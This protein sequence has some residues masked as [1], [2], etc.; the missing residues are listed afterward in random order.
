MSEI[1]PNLYQVLN[2]GRNAT[3]K[4]IMKAS[5]RLAIQF[6]PQL[7]PNNPAAAENFAK[8]QQAYYHLSDPQRR[9]AY[10]RYLDNPTSI[11]SL[12][13]DTKLEEHRVFTP[14]EDFVF[15]HYRNRNFAIGSCIGVGTTLTGIALT[16]FM[17]GELLGDKGHLGMVIPVFAGLVANVAYGV[18]KTEYDIRNYYKRIKGKAE[19]MV[20][21]KAR[22]LYNFLDSHKPDFLKRE[23]KKSL[24]RLIN[25][26]P[27]ITHPDNSD[28]KAIVMP[29]VTVNGM[30][31]VQYLHKGDVVQK[32]VSFSYTFE[33]DKQSFSLDEKL[34]R[35][36]PIPSSLEI[37]LGTTG[38]KIE[39]Q[40]DKDMPVTLITHALGYAKNGNVTPLFFCNRNNNPVVLCAEQNP[41]FFTYTNE[42]GRIDIAKA[43]EHIYNPRPKI[44]MSRRD[45]IL[46]TAAAT[47]FTLITIPSIYFNLT[48]IN[49]TLRSTLTE[50]VKSIPEFSLNPSINNLGIDYRRE[51]QALS[52][53]VQ[54]P[55]SNPYA[56]HAPKSPIDALFDNSVL[57]DSYGLGNGTVIG[58]NGHVLTSW[59]VIEPDVFSDY[60]GIIVIDKDKNAYEAKVVAVSQRYDLALLK[61]NIR[62]EHNVFLADVFG[63]QQGAPVFIGGLTLEGRI[64]YDGNPLRISNKREFRLDRFT[65]TG[66]FVENQDYPAIA[67]D[68]MILANPIKTSA[69]SRGGYSGS[70]VADT[71][72]RVICV[73]SMRSSVRSSVRTICS[74][75]ENIRR[76]IDL[77][78]NELRRYQTK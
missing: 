8:V 55:V 57:V 50:I 1:P 6:H 48:H 21:I 46:W 32:P 49:L 29:V 9:A 11:D 71:E 51:E 4:E 60:R 34:R 2:V 30:I 76:F 24:D 70:L 66:T 13:A 40:P 5:A 10:D 31:Y 64:N 18:I 3:E 77:Y 19:S 56:S 54:S 26:L 23:P 38:Q 17:T 75:A 43:V 47:A 35:I 61:T 7:N 36:A 22:E 28:F 73:H 65:S 74:S 62:G 15:S 33:G 45:K 68:G 37:P 44:R 69:F 72:G 12:I 16:Y 14:T 41:G 27:Q 59:H 39:F 67:S 42:Q 78:L 52:G 20:S 25:S 53:L 58:N 63:I